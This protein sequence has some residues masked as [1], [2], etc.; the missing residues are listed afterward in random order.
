MTSHF[1]DLWGYDV[2]WTLSEDGW[3]EEKRKQLLSL[4][5]RNQLQPKY[6]PALTDLGYKKMAIPH[7]LYKFIIDQRLEFPREV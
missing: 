2:A 7:R 6:V 4:H 1:A 3:D 5:A